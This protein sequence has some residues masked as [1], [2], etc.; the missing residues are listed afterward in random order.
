MKKLRKNK[1][2]KFINHGGQFSKSEELNARDIQSKLQRQDAIVRIDDQ[3]LNLIDKCIN[4]DNTMKAKWNIYAHI[5]TNDLICKYGHIAKWTGDK[6]F[7][8]IF[9]FI[10]IFI[11]VLI[12]ILIIYI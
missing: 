9:I 2:F 11:L 10:S 8:V 4:M 7:E 6:E 12:L 1:S 3:Y 5:V